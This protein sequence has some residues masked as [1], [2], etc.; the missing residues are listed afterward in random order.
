MK[1]IKEGDLAAAERLHMAIK[2][3]ICPDCGCIFEANKNE[4]ETCYQYNEASYGCK[5]P[6]CGAPVF[7]EE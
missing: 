3:F 1:V 7:T 6:T 5:C 2:H 4:Y